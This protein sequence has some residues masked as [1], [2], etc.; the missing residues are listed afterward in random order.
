MADTGDETGDWYSNQAAT[1]GDR[2]AGA[3]DAAG[4]SQ[5][6]LARRLGVKLKTLASWENDLAEPRAN[7]LQMVAGLL[8][9]SIVWLL[10]GEGE[11]VEAPEEQPDLGPDTTAILLEIRAMKTRLLRDAEHLGRLEKALRRVG[12]AE[13]PG[14]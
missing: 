13:A 8:N 7:K 14:A 12:G 4:L 6:G 1:F 3:R 5:S 2:L 10:T 11:G 9:V